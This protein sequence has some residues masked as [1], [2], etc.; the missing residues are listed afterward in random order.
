MKETKYLS[1]G[2]IHLLAIT[3]KDYE[4]RGSSIPKLSFDI[5]K[6]IQDFNNSIYYI[7]KVKPNYGSTPVD[8][9]Q[10]YVNEYGSS[11][12]ICAEAGAINYDDYI[13]KTKKEIK[14]QV[15]Q[16]RSD[17]FNLRF[18][19][20]VF[21]PTMSS[22]CEKDDIFMYKNDITEDF[23]NNAFNAEVIGQV[24]LKERRNNG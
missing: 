14:N 6:N 15:F 2:K 20:I 9:I 5:Y 4:E 18:M 24:R 19:N 23:M 21:T 11:I 3:K 1:S 12:Y 10:E 13:P 22:I 8:V 17:L 16:Q 7:Q